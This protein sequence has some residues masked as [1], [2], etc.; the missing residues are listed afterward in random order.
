MTA[1]AWVASSIGYVLSVA[2]VGAI[3]YAIEEAR[4]PNFDAVWFVW[5]IAWPLVLAALAVVGL[6]WCVTAPTYRLVAPRVKARNEKR[7]AAAERQAEIA[8]LERE[9]EVGQ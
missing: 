2:I 9:L 1:L 5:A 4:Y 6:L 7:G 8:K 3:W